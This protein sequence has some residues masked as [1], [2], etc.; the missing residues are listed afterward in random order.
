[1]NWTRWLKLTG[2]LALVLVL[3]FLVPVSSDVHGGPVARGILAVV[4]LAVLVLG[5]VQ[6]LR[7]HVLD[8]D[9]RADGLIIAIM[10]TVAVFALAF[11]SLELHNPG[12]VDGLK[13]R[14]DALYFTASTMLTIGYGD[15]HATGQAARV[16][17][18]VQIVFNAVFVATAVALLTTRVRRAAAARVA[19]APVAGEE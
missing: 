8:G 14:V 11:Y 4:V 2:V 12:Q 7:V 16:F 19:G 15:V 13:T 18:L 5:M 3:Y 1:M 17:I 9:R 6:Q 10:V